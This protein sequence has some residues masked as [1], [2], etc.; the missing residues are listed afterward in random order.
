MRCHSRVWEYSWGGCILISPSLKFTRTKLNHWLCREIAGLLHCQQSANWCSSAPKFSKRSQWACEDAQNCLS[1]N[2]RVEEF[3]WQRQSN[4]THAVCRRLKALRNWQA[5]LHKAWENQAPCPS[6]RGKCWRMIFEE[7]NL[8]TGEDNTLAEQ[9]WGRERCLENSWEQ[10]H[11]YKA[12]QRHD[13]HRL[14]RMK[15]A[16]PNLG[17]LKNHEEAPLILL[18]KASDE[19]SGVWLTWCGAKSEGVQSLHLSSSSEG[20]V[21]SFHRRVVLQPSKAQ[22]QVLDFQRRS[23]GGPSAEL[24]Q[25]SCS[26][27]CPV[28][29]GCA[30]FRVLKR[31]KLRMR[32]TAFLH[33]PGKDAQGKGR[34]TLWELQEEAHHLL[35]QRK[36]PFDGWNLHILPGQGA[37]SCDSAAVHAGME[38]CGESLQLGKD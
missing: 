22:V 24:Q 36:H 3:P 35:W 34:L 29:P 25:R 32:S 21:I 1:V 5:L 18:E 10:S 30:I 7:R 11:H 8:R 16:H 2:Q 19:A 9:D 6:I 33:G 38:P 12:H 37:A 27:V 15:F 20:G 14:R 26:H 31:H 28:R 4:F 23:K 17:D 13:W